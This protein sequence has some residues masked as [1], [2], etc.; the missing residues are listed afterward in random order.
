MNQDVFLNTLSS[1]KASFICGSY[2][3]CNEATWKDFDYIPAFNK[4]YLID[5]GECCCSVDGEEYYPK[6]GQ[7]MLLPANHLQSYS[8]RNGHPLIKYWCH[9]TAEVMNRSLFDV[10]KTDLVVDIPNFAA[11][12]TLFQRLYVPIEGTASDCIS[13]QLDRQ[14]ALTEIISRYISLSHAQYSENIVSAKNDF[15][16]VFEYI[17]HHLS[18]Q[19]TVEELSKTVHLH[20][21][22]FIKRFHE[23]YGI[24][25]IQHVNAERLE[26]AKYLLENTTLSISEISQKTGFCD[27]FYFSK[28][29]KKAVGF[30]P[31]QYRSVTQPRT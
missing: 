25:P 16:P 17:H 10:I 21:N 26:Q 18:K 13:V 8:M 11:A 5:Q 29:F 27:V 23:I 4:F 1:L 3:N 12:K 28:F 7:L 9:F 31:S 19:I 22:Y 14:A 2:T 20:P 24:S 6:A 30:S 15:Q